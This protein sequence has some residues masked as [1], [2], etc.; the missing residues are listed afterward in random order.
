MPLVRGNNPN[1]LQKR[2]RNSDR[3][4]KSQT[5]RY[6]RQHPLVSDPQYRQGIRFDRN[7]EQIFPW[8]HMW[9]SKFQGVSGAGLLGLHAG[10][11]KGTN[12]AS[13]LL[14]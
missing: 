12:L 11:F 10:I 4:A 13:N 6:P 9:F 14:L 7:L 1:D 2:S 5:V 3:H 8:K